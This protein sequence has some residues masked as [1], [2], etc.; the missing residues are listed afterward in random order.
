MRQ[1]AFPLLLG[2]VLLIPGSAFA[3]A[4]TGGFLQGSS[5]T[6]PYVGIGVAYALESFDLGELESASG[7]GLK[8]ANSLGFSARLGYRLHA[9]LAAELAFEY[10]DNVDLD[11][12]GVKS[13]EVD[14]W[15]LTGNVK[16]YLLPGPLQPYALAGFGVLR[17]DLPDIL[18]LG[19]KTEPMARFGGGLDLYVTEKVVFNAEAAY[20]LPT[21]ED[22][23]DLPFIPLVFG[24]QYRF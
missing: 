10:Y 24:L 11:A 23:E 17:A 4:G 5:R 12:V 18:P 1:N 13:A 7:T 19:D 20:V 14:A 15:L 8:A 9:H 22:L 2:A 21:G 6:G 3:Q 16:A